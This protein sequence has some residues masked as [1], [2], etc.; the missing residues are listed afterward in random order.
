MTGD[1]A[2]SYSSGNGQLRLSINTNASN[3]NIGLW[4][5]SANITKG[6][7]TSVNCYMNLT[8]TKIE[9]YY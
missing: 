6:H 9:Q 3:G 4:G 8:V 1:K 5:G 7:G 2:N